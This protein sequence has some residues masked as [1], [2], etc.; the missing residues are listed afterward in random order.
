MCG[1][2]CIIGKN[3]NKIVTEK[4]IISVGYKYLHRGPDAQN[5]YFENQFKCFFRRL[6]IIDLHKRSDQPFHSDNN[7]YVMAF[8]GEIYNFNILKKEL[9][10]LG[11]SFKTQGDTE[12]LI[13]AFEMWGKKFVNKLRGMFAICIWDK[14]LKVFYA[15]RD[16]FG[17]KPL[18]YTYYKNNFFFSSEI[19][20]IITL[21][22]KKKI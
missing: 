2:I 14:K 8:N 7:R 17:I 6:S 12:V 13:K 1:F 22:K 3:Q 18:Y 9:I 21:L 15:F 10:N 19:K 16:R 20:D 5:Y 11:N 4:E